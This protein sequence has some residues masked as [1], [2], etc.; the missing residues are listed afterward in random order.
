M[1]QGNGNNTWPAAAYLKLASHRPAAAGDAEKPISRST[2]RRHLQVPSSLRG[3]PGDARPDTSLKGAGI[4]LRQP[5]TLPVPT[6]KPLRRD[7]PR[8]FSIF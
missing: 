1:K 8:A 6:K 3:A 7:D 5:Q 2:A 4:C